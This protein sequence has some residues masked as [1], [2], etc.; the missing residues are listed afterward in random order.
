[1]PLR[2]QSDVKKIESVLNEILNAHNP[3]VGRCRTPFQRVQSR[4]F[5]E[6]H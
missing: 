5:A 3:P 6:H 1:M 4:A 2:V